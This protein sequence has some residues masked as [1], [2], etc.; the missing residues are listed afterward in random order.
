MEKE[1]SVSI[2]TKTWGRDSHGLYDYETV[3]FKAFEGNI[4]QECKILRKK[5]EIRTI[6]PAE[7]SFRDE[8][9]LCEI[10]KGQE[11]KLKAIFIILIL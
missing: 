8:E 4:S 9:L 5:L 3:Q 11:S 1:I 6:E 2:A 7:E 10:R